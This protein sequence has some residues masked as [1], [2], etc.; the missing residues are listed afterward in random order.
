MAADAGF[1]GTEAS[2]GGG[3][4]ARAEGFLLHVDSFPGVGRGARLHTGCYLRTGANGRQWR[5][6]FDIRVIDHLILYTQAVLISKC[7]K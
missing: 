4:R 1:W 2:L 3:W 7:K 6:N 5:N